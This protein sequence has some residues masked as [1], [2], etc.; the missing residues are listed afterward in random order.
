MCSLTVLLWL[1]AVLGA[2][3]TV[4]A[5][6]EPS[7]PVSLQ[8][9]IVDTA[10]TPHAQC[11]RL[12]LQPHHQLIRCTAH[13]TACAGIFA[14][15]V[16]TPEGSFAIVLPQHSAV[17]GMSCPGGSGGLCYSYFYHGAADNWGV[18]EFNP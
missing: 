10:L 16:Y 5:A 14:Q 15:D 13:N 2:P 12:P 6:G 11:M 3:A 7:V 9:T 4:R 1:G 8:R 18:E 17:Y